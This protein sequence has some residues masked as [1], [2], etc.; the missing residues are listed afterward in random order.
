M[1]Y[2]NVNKTTDFT[3]LK[4]TLET[5]ENGVL[6]VE[7]AVY[8]I[9]IRYIGNYTEDLHNQKLNTDFVTMNSKIKQAN[10]VY[11]PTFTL[12]NNQIMFKMDTNTGVFDEKAM[13]NIIA[14][15]TLAQNCLNA[16]KH[17][18]QQ[19]FPTNSQKGE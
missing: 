15:F 3:I 13:N 12:V 1:K 18:I 8:R 16:F 4:N 17:I 6:I 19:Y 9:K 14:D 2:N 11:M 10:S 7:N 5:Q